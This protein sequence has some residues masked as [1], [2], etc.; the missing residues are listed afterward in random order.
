MDD[1]WIMWHSDCCH[2]AVWTFSVYVRSGSASTG[3]A[4]T[5]PTLVTPAGKQEAGLKDWLTTNMVAER[6]Y[7]CFVLL[8]RSLETLS[9]SPPL[10]VLPWERDL[11]GKSPTKYSV[12]LSWRP[13][14]TRFWGGVLHTSWRAL[15]LVGLHPDFC[16]CWNTETFIHSAQKLS[17][18]GHLCRS[19][20]CMRPLSCWPLLSLMFG[21]YLGLKSPLQI[22]I[23]WGQF[24]QDPPND[25]IQMIFFFF[26]RWL[27]N[28]KEPLI[29][30]GAPGFKHSRSALSSLL[31]ISY[32]TWLCHMTIASVSPC[33][34]TSEQQGV[35][36]A[37]WPAHCWR[38]L[39]GW[40]W[41]QL[42]M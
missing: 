11:L 37:R 30:H 29:S 2:D 19:H 14:H 8:Q 13:F 26:F 23:K 5:P 3:G 16:S 20:L 27:A 7:R 1:K 34:L 33:S 40:L 31:G 12:I 39:P 6:S 4:G 15:W 28:L 24:I 18:S 32:I 21:G 17:F 22:R 42:K 41:K 10:L 38:V 9:D 25:W 36:S 35:L